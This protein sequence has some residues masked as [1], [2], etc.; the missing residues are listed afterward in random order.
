MNFD[1]LPKDELHSQIIQAFEADDVRASADDIADVLDFDME[2]YEAVFLQD[3]IR[4]A[5]YD[6]KE[7]HEQYT[8]PFMEVCKELT[9][10]PAWRQFKKKRYDALEL[11]E[12]KLEDAEGMSWV[13]S[14]AHKLGKTV[15][16]FVAWVRATPAPGRG[17]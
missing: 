4:Q 6:G 13:E 15:E 3:V 1:H 17:T 11:V 2:L 9:T 8:T 14:E 5:S 16:E 10:R 12:S 7:K